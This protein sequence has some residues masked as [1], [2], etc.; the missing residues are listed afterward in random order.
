MKCP[1]QR[2]AYALFAGTTLFLFFVNAAQA[3]SLEPGMDR[4]GMDHKR[5]D[6]RVANPELCQSECVADAQCRAFTYVKPGVMGS[7]P[8]CFL[9]SGTPPATSNDCCVSGLKR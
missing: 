8:V 7:T 5:I 4:L 3:Q 9:K 6:L 1:L 2:L